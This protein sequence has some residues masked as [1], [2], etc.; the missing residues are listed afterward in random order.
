MDN[1]TD[2]EKQFHER[3]MRVYER[4]QSECN[5]NATDFL[6]M[7]NRQGGLAT[8]K[9]LLNTNDLSYGLTRLWEE[10]RLDLSMEA[11]VLEDAWRS[12]F[13]ADELAKAK[14]TLKELGYKFPDE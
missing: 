14:K 9:Q 13:T 11:A 1:Q 4:A 6:G 12:L 3:M 5:Y 10:M 2:L 7:L 8:A